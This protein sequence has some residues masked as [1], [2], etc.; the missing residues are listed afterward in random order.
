MELA[1]YAF[2]GFLVVCLVN[3]LA[4]LYYQGEVFGTGETGMISVVSP[5]RAQSMRRFFPAQ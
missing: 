3:F 2:G 4:F 1:L 5:E